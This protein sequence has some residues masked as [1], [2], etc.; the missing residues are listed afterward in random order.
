MRRQITQDGPRDL[1]LTCAA[2]LIADRNE[3]CRWQA[4]AVVAECAGDRLE[5]VWELLL[6]HGSSDDASMRAALATGLLE[7]LLERH[8]DTYFPLLRE[9]LERR[10][11]RLADTLRRCWLF[12]GAKRL[13]REVDRLLRSF[14]GGG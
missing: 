13:S 6:R 10:N 3:S 2:Q 12:G 14:G 7:R 9:Q 1:Y 5:A 8:Y 4:L 11:T